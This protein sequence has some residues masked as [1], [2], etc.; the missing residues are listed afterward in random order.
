MALASCRD[1]GNDAPSGIRICPYCGTVA[2]HS[3]GGSV[4]ARLVSFLLLAVLI[5]WLWAGSC[6]DVPVVVFVGSGRW[7]SPGG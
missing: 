2:P 5:G 6:A 7:L 3:A 1:C 4:R